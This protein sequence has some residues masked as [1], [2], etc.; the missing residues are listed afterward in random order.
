MDGESV[1]GDRIMKMKIGDYDQLIKTLRDTQDIE[2]HREW[3]EEVKAER[4]K[5]IDEQELKKGQHKVV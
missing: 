3:L 1:K 2:E 4:K 5:L